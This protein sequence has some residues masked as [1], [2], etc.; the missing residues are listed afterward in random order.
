MQ[1]TCTYEHVH[2]RVCKCYINECD[3]WPHHFLVPHASLVMLM[4]S[5]VISCRPDGMELPMEKTSEYEAH[6]IKVCVCIC[7][8]V[9]SVS[10]VIFL[11]TCDHHLTVK[12]VSSQF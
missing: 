3:N 2:V 12:Y 8:C 7:V 4:C 9:Y 5:D 6:D 1:Y 10:R 11:C